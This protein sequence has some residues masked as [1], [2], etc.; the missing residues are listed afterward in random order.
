[1]NNE[2]DVENSEVMVSIQVAAVEGGRARVTSLSGNPVVT[3]L[4]ESLPQF[5]RPG[6][7]IHYEVCRGG[8]GVT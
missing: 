6:K 1:M 5:R 8:L 7:N 4:P 3:P 2:V